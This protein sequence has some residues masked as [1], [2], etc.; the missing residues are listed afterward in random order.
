MNQNVERDF[1]NLIDAFEMIDTLETND[2]N[3][4]MKQEEGE[5]S[6][7]KQRDYVTVDR[8]FE[9]VGRDYSDK[10][11]FLNQAHEFCENSGEFDYRMFVRKIMSERVMKN[12]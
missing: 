4:F 6:Q 10:Q 9:L 11:V 12:A 7:K 1:Q 3:K 2:A 5:V 8:L